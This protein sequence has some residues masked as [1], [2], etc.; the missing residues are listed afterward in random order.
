MSPRRMA[1]RFVLAIA[2]SFASASAAFCAQIVGVVKSDAGQPVQGIKISAIDS[3]SGKLAGDTLTGADGR[4]SISGLAKGKYVFKLDPLATG[5]Q[6]GDGVAYLGDDG[7]TVDWSVSP[8]A[9]A[10]DGATPGIGAGG[11]LAQAS[12]PPVIDPGYVMIGGVL[13]ATGIGLGVA[14]GTGALGGS[15]SGPSSSPHM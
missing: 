1:V 3:A 11:V 4:Y 12:P 7:L 14:A 5:F 15:S 10:L 2:I 8:S 6:P 13:V 9:V